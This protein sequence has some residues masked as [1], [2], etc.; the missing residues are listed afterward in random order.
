MKTVIDSFPEELTDYVFSD[1]QDNVW[2]NGHE[3]AE[4][5]D[6]LRPYWDDYVRDREAVGDPVPEGLTPELYC[7]IWDAWYKIRS[8]IEKE[9]ME[10]SNH[11]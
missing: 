11:G 9:V 7:E 8:S 3:P 6:V 1:Y 5:V 4:P 2:Y 10:E